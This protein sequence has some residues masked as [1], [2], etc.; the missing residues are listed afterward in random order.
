MSLELR[1]E[2]KEET[3]LRRGPIRL[4]AGLAVVCASI[5]LAVVIMEVASRYMYRVD[6]P[7]YVNQQG[8]EDTLYISDEELGFRCK[9]NYN[10][11]LTSPEFRTRVITNSSG[12]RATRDFEKPANGNRIMTFGDSF[13]FGYGVEYE[14]TYSAKIEEGLSRLSTTGVEVFDFGTPAYGT[15]QEAIVF[16][17]FKH[18]KPD[19]VVIGLLARD[20]V[21]EEGGNDFVDNYNFFHLKKFGAFDGDAVQQHGSA[22]RQIRK[23]LKQYSNLYRI[24]ELHLGSLLRTFYRPGAGPTDLI[25]DSR[26]ITAECLRNFDHSLGELGIRGIILWIP[27]PSSVTKSDHS[28]AQWLQSLELKNFD[29]VDVVSR[30]KG[31]AMQYYFPLDGHWNPKGHA[32]AAEAVVEAIVKQGEIRNAAMRTPQGD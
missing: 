32:L 25:A 13:T 8:E 17:R 15:L 30:F 1:S 20:T 4:L 5:L 16:D 9:S 31:S 14:E 18:L 11:F 3:R 6:R 7:R 12:Y 28:V 19:L 27:F 24:F 26:K 29:V 2:M 22:T 10:G 23:W 21:V